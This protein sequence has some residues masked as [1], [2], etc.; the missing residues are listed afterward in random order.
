MSRKTNVSSDAWA[1]KIGGSLYDSE[2]L[3]QW[4]KVINE[5]INRDIVIIPGGG[6]F[7]DQVRSADKKFKLGVN[8]HSMAVMA[9]QQYGGVLASLCTDMVEADTIEKV[10]IAW[11]KSKTAI[12]QPYEMVR[13]QCELDACWDVSS[14]SLAV[15]LASKL[16]INNLLLVKSSDVVIGETNLDVLA[17]S[18]CIDPELK[19][20]ANKYQVNI[21]LSHKSKSNDLPMYMHSE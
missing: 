11:S 4:L 5:R 10:H 2:Y 14:D 21:H 1:I 16:E 3:I 6:P 15:W 20:L 17:A 7:A 13:D 8:A 9:M 19:E 12:W 18:H